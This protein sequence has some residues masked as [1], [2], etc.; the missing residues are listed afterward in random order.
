MGGSARSVSRIALSRAAAGLG[1]ASAGAPG[2]AGRLL[3]P[4]HLRALR[5][6]RIAAADAALQLLGQWSQG[7]ADAPL[8]WAPDFYRANRQDYAELARQTLWQYRPHLEA[9]EEEYLAL[10]DGRCVLPVAYVL[11]YGH[12]M[13]GTLAAWIAQ[14]EV[15]LED[16]QLT[17]DRRVNWLLARG[18]AQELRRNRPQ[19]YRRPVGRFLAGEGY[20]Q[21]ATL[22]AESEPLRLRAYQELAVRMT[23]Y[24]RI[25]GARAMLD[26]AAERCTSA[27]STEALT[28]WRGELEALRL[29]FQERHEQQEAAARRRTSSGSK[30][31]GSGRCA[32]RLPGRV[33]YEQL[34][35]EAGA[36]S[37]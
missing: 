36:T 24:E 27:A 2:S 26:R 17:G 13:D 32:W 29:A 23:A 19:R 6:C 8:E 33:R 4:R 31:G 12:W 3:A 7:H 5:H 34:L 15:R 22:V 28:Q 21:E 10:P 35:A 1:R 18:Q 9:L 11:S 30:H 25:D 14:L 16:A 20:L 37:P